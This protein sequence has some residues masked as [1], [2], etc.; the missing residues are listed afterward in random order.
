MGLWSFIKRLAKNLGESLLGFLLPQSDHLLHLESL[1]PEKLL[2]IL[3]P[4]NFEEGK[5]TLALFDYSDPTVKEII[6]EVKYAGNRTL[7][8][9][10][11]AILFDV[12]VAE[13]MERNL[14][15]KYGAVI[16]MPMPV[17][18]KR[19]FER[20]WNQVELITNAVKAR[21]SA[22]HFKY[23]PRML[24]KITHTESQTRTAH[25]RERR[26]NLINTMQV[27]NP[28]SVAG[29]L[30]VLIDDVITTGSTFNEAKRSLKEAGAK[31]IICIALSH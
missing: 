11:G 23:L 19:R 12:I 22:Q 10:L 17:S 1:T 27:M 29:R 31:K 16:L 2:Q 20:G 28:Q 5:D 9:K 4:A 3:P 13:L 8:D 7:A 18:D 21:D 14:L 15:E 6:W 24:A 25:K 26:E 30:V